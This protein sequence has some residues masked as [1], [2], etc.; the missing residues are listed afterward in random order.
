MSQQSPSMDGTISLNNFLQAR[1][2][3]TSLVWSE[4]C[5]GPSHAPI[6]T[7]VCKINGEVKGTGIGPQ[8]HVARDLAAK[9]ALKALQEQEQKQ[10]KGAE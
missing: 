5:E 3:L 2:R 6:W 8:K 10:A 7:S 4:T 1:N 9:E